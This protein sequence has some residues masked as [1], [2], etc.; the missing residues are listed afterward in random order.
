MLGRLVLV[1]ALAACGWIS[2][3]G[4]PASASAATYRTT[5][6]DQGFVSRRWTPWGNAMLSGK[7]RLWID[8]TA[9]SRWS[10]TASN[11]YTKFYW[12]TNGFDADPTWERKSRNQ[13]FAAAG[14]SFGS[15]A[16]VAFRIKWCWKVSDGSKYR[17][18]ATILGTPY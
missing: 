12:S 6:W 3:A 4:A 17:Y 2:F 8:V 9:D 7:T 10:F 11:R 15:S 18:A 16:G 1:F 5:T 14:S 13:F